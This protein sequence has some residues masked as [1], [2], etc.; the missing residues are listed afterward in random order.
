MSEYAGLEFQLCLPRQHPTDEWFHT[1]FQRLW[2]HGFSFST[3]DRA[4]WE[5]AL[6]ATGYS[7]VL[8][9]GDIEGGSLATFSARASTV[10]D[11]LINVFNGVSRLQFSFSEF[12]SASDGAPD[13]ADSAHLSYL[14]LWTYKKD[15]SHPGR[16][17]R[18]YLHAYNAFLHTCAL[19]CEALDPLYGVGYD[20]HQVR[21]QDAIASFDTAAAPDLL[22][23]N[24]PNVSAWFLS[25]PLQYIAPRFLTPERTLTWLASPGVCV[26]RLAT[27]GLFITPPIMPYT[28]ESSIA[29]DHL[30]HGN[31]KALFLARAQHGQLAPQPTL[32]QLAQARREGIAALARASSIFGSIND[33]EG[34]QQARYRLSEL[35]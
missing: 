2:T 34:E 5:D 9:D 22:A 13:D 10:A 28:Y 21:D 26:R 18:P 15:T 3:P 31:S 29:H 24:L 32:E 12:A 33:R 8:G 16:G 27:G 14:A 4:N 11:S 25:E 20:L 19:L 7:F 30:F 35:E 17:G 6:T 1:L 23:G